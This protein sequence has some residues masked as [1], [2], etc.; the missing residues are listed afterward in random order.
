MAKEVSRTRRVGQELQ[1]EIAMILQREVKDPRI[2]MVTVSGVEVSRDLSH[3]KVFITL[4]DQDEAKVKETLKGLQEAKPYIR[5]LVG[6]R[7]RLRI[8]PELKFVHD[9]SLI[10][11]MRISNAVSQAVAADEAKKAASGREDE[12]KE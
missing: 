12:D 7:L 11:G 9:T 6:G 3:A 5:S 1:R 2:G 10:E 8:V 4:F